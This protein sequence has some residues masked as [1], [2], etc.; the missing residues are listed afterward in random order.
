MQR[1]KGVQHIREEDADGRAPSAYQL[2]LHHPAVH[3]LLVESEAEVRQKRI[4]QAPRRTGL[5][6]TVPE[7]G[8]EHDREHH[9]RDDEHL[10]KV[11]LLRC[12]PGMGS[13]TLRH[14]RRREAQSAACRC[15]LTPRLSTTVSAARSRP[16]SS[17]PAPLSNRIALT[18]PAPSQ[19][20]F[21]LRREGHRLTNHRGTTPRVRCASR[22]AEGSRSPAAMN[23]GLRARPA[24]PRHRGSPP[25]DPPPGSERRAKCQ[26]HASHCAAAP[27]WR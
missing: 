18:V 26:R 9:I 3:E 4:P 24:A 21:F 2:Q 16:E 15:Q 27:R 22:A 19:L 20:H 6:D 25:R 23:R 14:Q 5:R 13:L 10:E 12:G 8:S 17:I 7:R 11:R 1:T